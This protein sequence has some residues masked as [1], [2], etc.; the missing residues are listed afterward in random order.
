MAEGRTAFALEPDDW[1]VEPSWCTSFLLERESFA[2]S[3]V[4]DPA[5]GQGN[6]VST[7][8][9]AGIQA[10]GTDL[11][12]RTP[13]NLVTD[14]SEWFAG[15]RNFLDGSRATPLAPAVTIGAIVTNPPYGHAKL[16][17]EFIRHAG[18]FPQVRKLAVFVNA[19]FMFGRARAAGLFT[20][21]PPTRIW[22]ILPRPSC[23]PGQ[24]LEGGGRATGGVADYIWMVWDFGAA[25]GLHHAGRQLT[26]IGW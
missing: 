1:Y 9:T 17:E 12:T 3:D 5:C 20:E 13:H 16:A 24:Y 15:E 21:L 25:R 2:G 14:R 22:P 11:R 4:W 18:N 10:F 23:P 8:R 26:G 7:L 19:K 6:I